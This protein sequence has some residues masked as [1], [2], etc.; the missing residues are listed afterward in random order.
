MADNKYGSGANLPPISRNN[1]S[2]G[3]GYIRSNSKSEQFPISRQGSSRRRFSHSN[4]KEFAFSG[5]YSMSNSKSMAQEGGVPESLGGV[6]IGGGWQLAY[7]WE[8]GSKDG[9]EGGLKRVFLKGEG[10]ELSR[11]QSNM[12][13]PGVGPQHSD[14]ESIQVDCHLNCFNHI[15]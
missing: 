7:R 14:M 11:F 4:S 5:R 10:G 8:E 1:S 2:R 13:L 3:Q 12:T 15:L 6:G 9:D